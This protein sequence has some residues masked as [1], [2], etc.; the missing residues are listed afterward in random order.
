MNPVH[1]PAV[2]DM[3]TPAAANAFNDQTDVIRVIEE[4]V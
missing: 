3:T 2:R 4:Q 1:T